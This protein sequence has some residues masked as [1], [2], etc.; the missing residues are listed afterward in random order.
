MSTPYYMPTIKIGDVTLVP[1]RLTSTTSVPTVTDPVKIKWGTSNWVD[2]IKPSTLD[3]TI[4][5]PTG[6]YANPDE[7]IGTMIVITVQIT[8]DY[9]ETLWRG[10]IYES[11]A[12]WRRVRTADGSDRSVWVVSIRAQDPLAKLAR[13]YTRGRDIG[14]STPY[15]NLWTWMP[16][17]MPDRITALREKMPDGMGLDVIVGNDESRIRCS[18]WPT[19]VP[20]LTVLQK[21][22]RATGTARRVIYDP[23]LHRASVLEPPETDPNLIPALYLRRYRDETIGIDRQTALTG[24]AVRPASMIAAPSGITVE[25]TAADRITSVTVTGHIM[26]TKTGSNGGEP[27][28]FAWNDDPHQVAVPGM[29]SAAQQNTDIDISYMVPDIGSLWNPANDLK[30]NWASPPASVKQLGAVLAATAK[31]V[32]IGDAEVSTPTDRRSIEA[33]TFLTATPG[34]GTIGI[35]GSPI[36]GLPFT[37]ICYAILGGTLTWSKRRWTQRF[38]PT[39]LPM[40]INSDLTLADLRDNVAG[41]PPATLDMVDDSITL[42]DLGKLYSGYISA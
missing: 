18:G 12:K 31:L 2:D 20:V 24:I 16:H 30:I 17:K 22:V 32:R 29:A 40:R 38:T 33:E 1:G 42:A 19:P 3:L 28:G 5:D 8:P 6:R 36:S 26:E 9:T 15:G 35:I 4:L 39:P 14:N 11:S 37:T 27:T 41:R 25:S 23:R 10:H 34:P 21:T 13:D 7:H